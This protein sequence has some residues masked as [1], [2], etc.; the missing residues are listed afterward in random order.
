MSNVIHPVPLDLTTLASVTG[1]T[2]QGD[3]LLN[4]LSSL[5]SQVKNLSTQTQGFSPTTML[6]LCMVALQRN[7]N[8]SA[9]YVYVSGRPH[10]WF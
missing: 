8:A 4:D 6:L 7:Q 3:P 2:R 10:G 9:S 5:A 1:G